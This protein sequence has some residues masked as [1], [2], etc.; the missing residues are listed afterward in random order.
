MILTPYSSPANPNV[1]AK[2][3]EATLIIIESNASF[4]PVSLRNSG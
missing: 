3:D 4:K 2:E 1:P